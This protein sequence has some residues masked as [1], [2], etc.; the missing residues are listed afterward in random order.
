MNGSPL[1][2]GTFLDVGHIAAGLVIGVCVGI[3]HFRLLKRYA[4]A[5]V[6]GGSLTEAMSLLIARVGATSFALYFVAHLGALPLIAALI[7]IL[8][9]QRMTI[10]RSGA[11]R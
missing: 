7:G 6:T 3:V 1:I 8:A 4:D 11:A 5:C 2:F 9:A 10:H